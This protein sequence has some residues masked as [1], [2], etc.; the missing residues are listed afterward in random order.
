MKKLTIII[1]A[2][3]IAAVAVLFILHFLTPKTSKKEIAAQDA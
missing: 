3:L 1:N 2:V